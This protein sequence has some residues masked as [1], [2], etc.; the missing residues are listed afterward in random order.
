MSFRRKGID[1]HSGST[2]SNQDAEEVLKK[3]Q[4]E[5]QAQQSRAKRPGQL[6][7]QPGKRRANREQEVED[8]DNTEEVLSDSFESDIESDHSE[9]T[10][11]KS[12]EWQKRQ[13]ILQQHWQK[14]LVSDQQKIQ[15]YVAS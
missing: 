13:E 3:L 5:R 10:A 4:A 1:T 9:G 11:G 8:L 2:I 15:S 6:P 14:R 12:C 7:T